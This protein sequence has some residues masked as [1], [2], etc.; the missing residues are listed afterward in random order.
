VLGG[1]ARRYAFVAPGDEA[2]LVSGGAAAAG[3]R[4]DHGVGAEQ[5]LNPAEGAV[6]PFAFG[7]GVTPEAGLKS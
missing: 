4:G 6:R 7:A 3:D 1:R 5:A 2:Y